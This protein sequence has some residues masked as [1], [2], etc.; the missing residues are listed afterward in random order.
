[1][2]QSEKQTPLPLFCSIYKTRKKEGMY[3]YIPSTDDFSSV[4]SALMEKFGNPELVMHIPAKTRKTLF[5]KREILSQ[6]FETDGFYLQ[7]PPKQ[8]NW[9]AEHREA[10][11][12]SSQPPKE[13]K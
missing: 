12:L 1:M 8:E 11:G 4:P 7:M 13:E 5:V 10:L 9:L 3:L 2:K 6:S